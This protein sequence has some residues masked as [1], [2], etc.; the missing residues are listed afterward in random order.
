[1]P[2]CHE[3]P[4]PC[5][6]I[7]LPGICEPPLPEGMLEL[8]GNSYTISTL[9]FIFRFYLLCY[10]LFGLLLN[11]W[12]CFNQQKLDI[13]LQNLHP[14]PTHTPP[15]PC[16]THTHTQL[17]YSFGCLLGTTRRGNILS[18]VLSILGCS[19]SH[20]SNKEGENSILSI[21][22]DFLFHQDSTSPTLKAK[23]STWMRCQLG[24]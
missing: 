12:T 14:H 22:S 10:S 1:M 13:L 17:V 23:L 4:E 16:H 7:Q 15:H 3:L 24:T 8:G 6:F 9:D 2:K 21:G 18:L 20:L 11:L 19:C 5:K